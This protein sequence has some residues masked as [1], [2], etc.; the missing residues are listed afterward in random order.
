MLRKALMRRSEGRRNRHE[1]LV[2]YVLQIDKTIFI[3][4][5]ILFMVQTNAIISN[6][7][8]WSNI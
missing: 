4:I 7:A 1:E 5:Q 3:S 2:E 6:Y 8:G